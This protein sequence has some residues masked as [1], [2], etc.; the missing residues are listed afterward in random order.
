[1]PEQTVEFS[2]TI[3]SAV[4]QKITGTGKVVSLG[5]SPQRVSITNNNIVQITFAITITLTFTL[6]FTFKFLF[7][8]STLGLLKSTEKPKLIETKDLPPPVECISTELRE[9][10]IDGYIVVVREFDD[11][12]DAMYL[13]S[14]LRQ[15][16]VHVKSFV[17][18][19]KHYVY[20]GPLYAKRRASS[21][22]QAVQNLGYTEAYILYPN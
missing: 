9:L 6:A 11:F 17:C 7:G 22:L 5:T 18:R 21:A 3:Q 2:G 10:G 12:V 1:M 8:D 4:P 13:V 14:V 15:Q 20:V 19:S 16:R